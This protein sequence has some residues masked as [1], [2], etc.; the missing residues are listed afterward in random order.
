MSTSF[1]A[2]RDNV[3]QATDL[4][5]LVG[6]HVSLRPKGREFAGLCP[7]HD[8]SNPSMMVSP[9]KQIFKCFVCGAGGSCF[10]FVMRYHKLEFREALVMLA[11]RAGIELTRRGDREGQGPRPRKR[12]TEINGRA[13]GFFQAMLRDPAV[14]AEARGYLERRGVTADVIERFNL[15]YAPDGWETLALAARQERWPIADLEAAGLIKKR[16]NGTHYDALRHRLVFPISDSIGRPIAFGGRK[17]REEDEP[18]YLNSP[19]TPL[20]DK[21]STLYG[22]DLAKKTIIDRHLAIIVE[23]YTDVIACHQY[24]ATNVVAALG[25]AL[26]EKHARELRRY[27]EKAVLIL[28]GDAAGQKAADRAIELFLTA[29]IDVAIAVLPQGGDPDEFLRQHGLDAWDQAVRQAKDALTYVFEA[30]Q[31]ELTASD[32][33]TGQQ[34]TAEAFLTRLANLGFARTGDLR[35]NLIIQQLSG[36]LKLSPAAIAQQLQTREQQRRQQQQRRQASASSRLPTSSSATTRNSPQTTPGDADDRWSPHD[37]DYAASVL[38]DES[39][40]DRYMPIPQDA[41]VAALAAV[42]RGVVLAERQVIGV[43]LRYPDLLTLEL[44]DGASLDEAVDPARFRT[45]L[46]RKAYA[47]LYDYLVDAPTIALADLLADLQEQGRSGSDEV[48]QVWVDAEREA[49]LAA[50]E[51]RASE[52]LLRGAAE[53]LRRNDVD[54][55]G[56]PTVTHPPDALRRLQQLRAAPPDHALPA[57]A[58]NKTL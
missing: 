1:G 42:P 51:K 13:L 46:H 43:L 28:D 48:G 53:C 22:L 24:G 32:S 34:T 41:A 31:R 20:F 7:F 57:K 18:K 2:D 8:D 52:S 12:L 38:D 44:E 36:L 19:E 49:E 58:L 37:E 5:R 9:Q 27:A 21:S 47:W 11:E 4:V 25:T 10:D 26:T 6:E 39:Q 17:L 50:P 40:E 14:G 45:L 15:G 33:I 3:R 54:S 56:Q 30:A 55:P 35:R 16:D 29:D 23:G